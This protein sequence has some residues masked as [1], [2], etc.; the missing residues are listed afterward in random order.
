MERAN[1]NSCE[2]EE[3]KGGGGGEKVKTNRRSQKAERELIMIKLAVLTC[4]YNAAKQAPERGAC[5]QRALSPGGPGLSELSSANR[6]RWCRRDTREGHTQRTHTH[7]R[8]SI[9]PSSIWLRA[10][11]R[12]G[13]NSCLSEPLHAAFYS[14]TP[15]RSVNS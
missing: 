1:T 7:T 9:T 12:L 15:D 6:C 13:F 11:F 3:I 10:V 2:K 8:R 4:R 14:K 5:A